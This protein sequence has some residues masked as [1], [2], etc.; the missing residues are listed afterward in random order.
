[1]KL[2]FEDYPRLLF[3]ELLNE[4]KFTEYV[5]DFPNLKVDALLKHYQFFNHEQLKNEL[6]NIYSDDKKHLPPH[7]LLQ[8]LI[9]NELDSVY[10]EVTKLLHLL[11]TLPATT[12][13]SERSMSTLKRVKTYLRNSMSDN[14]LSCLSILAIEKKLLSEM[15]VNSAFLERV[16]DLFAEKKNRRIELIY[17]K[18]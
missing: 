16:I 15:S 11:L 1:M 4:K 17:K 9:M 13:S 6:S 14:R 10:E 18:I 8:Y 12:A 7:A 5:K 3:V 2:R